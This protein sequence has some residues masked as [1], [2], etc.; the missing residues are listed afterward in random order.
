L[1]KQARTADDWAE[2][3][4]GVIPETDATSPPSFHKVNLQLPKGRS[5]TFSTSGKLALFTASPQAEL[6]W[7]DTLFQKQPKSLVMNLRSGTAQV[8]EAIE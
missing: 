5:F 4:A 7:T 3:A 6:I 8:R 1:I 2:V